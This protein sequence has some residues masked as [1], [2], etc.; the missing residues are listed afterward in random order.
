MKESF[1]AQNPQITAQV[2][3]KARQLLYHYFGPFFWAILILLAATLLCL[4]ACIQWQNTMPFWAHIM[5]QLLVAFSV[6]LVVLLLGGS[7]LYCWLRLR[8]QYDLLLEAKNKVLD[9][10]QMMKKAQEKRAQRER[11]DAFWQKMTAWQVEMEA[12]LQKINEQLENP[13]SLENPSD[14]LVKDKEILIEKERSR[15]A[16]RMETVLCLFG[17][18]ATLAVSIK[19]TYASLKDAGLIPEGVE[20]KMLQMAD[21]LMQKWQE[22]DFS[23]KAEEK[24]QQFVDFAALQLK[25]ME[26]F[27]DQQL[28]KIRHNGKKEE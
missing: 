28:K 2:K 5:G 25:N 19:S 26:D 23:G 20:Q 10:R 18:I 4:L 27:L 17:E 15:L 22:I 21:Q 9:L 7:I 1:F 16:E 24:Y 12:Q 3:K 14:G 6:I 8:L 13:V 11:E